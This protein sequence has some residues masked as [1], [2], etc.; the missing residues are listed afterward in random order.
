MTD[1]G[2]EGDVQP[3][4]TENT[5]KALDRRNFL[6][7]CSVLAAASFAGAL[8]AHAAT[9][10]GVEGV[11]LVFKKQDRIFFVPSQWL[12]VFEITDLYEAVPLDKVVKKI[13]KED[14]GKSTHASV[15]YGDIADLVNPLNAAEVLL[16]EVPTENRTYVAAMVS[17]ATI[18]AT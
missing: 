5:W 14:H 15:L 11:F 17:P 12:E 8:P 9:A 10:S 3:T 1:S 7:N 6:L 18:G 16:P 13:R 2:A 4:Q